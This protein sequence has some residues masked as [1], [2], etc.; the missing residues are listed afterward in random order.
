MKH[1]DWKKK[2]IVGISG[3]SGII[4]GIRLLEFLKANNFETHLITSK[5]AQQTRAY[6]TAISAKELA[7]LADYSYNIHDISAAIA[8]G[9]CKTQ[10]MVI[11]PCSMHT[12]AEIAGAN[13]SNLLTRAADVILKERRKLI[14][15]VRETPL[16]LGHLHNMV[17]ATEMGA[18][19][20]PPLPA[21]YTKPQSLE[22]IIN[23]SVGRTLDLLDID[24]D[25]VK[26]WG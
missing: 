4:Y 24:N 23:H 12:L 13:S 9:S 11:A 14:L 20:A 16:H 25:L 2:I 17:K 19:I 22:D 18:I 10:G 6:E 3:A 1:T 5:A 7:E 8:S 21:F 15:M 26:R